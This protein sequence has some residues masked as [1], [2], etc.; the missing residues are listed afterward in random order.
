MRTGQTGLVPVLA[1]LLHPFAMHFCGRPRLGPANEAG[2]APG[3][4][5]GVAAAKAL[6]A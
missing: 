4:G 5:V 2:L 1:H 3:W 6:P